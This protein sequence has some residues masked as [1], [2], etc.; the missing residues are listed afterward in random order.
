MEKLVVA[1]LT[2][3]FSILGGNTYAQSEM[4]TEEK[5]GLMQD[6]VKTEI[7]V[8]QLPTQVSNALASP[9]YTG[10][11]I[12]KVWKITKGGETAYKVEFVKEGESHIVKFSESGQV[13]KNEKSKS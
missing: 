9:E 1:F 8:S 11:N 3:F 6:K 13:L 2:L 10:H 12:G 5:K 4:I 7:S